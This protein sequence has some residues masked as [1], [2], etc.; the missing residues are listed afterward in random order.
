MAGPDVTR[1]SK[2]M[3]SERLLVQQYCE[4]AFCAPIPDNQWMVEF[5]N[6]F[7]IIIASS[8]LQALTFAG[9]PPSAQYEPYWAPATEEYRWMCEN[10]IIVRTDYASF[11]LLGVILI[12][13]IG[14]VIILVNLSLE[15]V[16]TFVQRA[17]S[18][19]MREWRLTSIFQLQKLAVD[20][21]NNGN[22]KPADDGIPVGDRR[23]QLR[24]LYKAVDLKNSQATSMEAKETLPSG[25]QHDAAATRLL[26][27]A[28]AL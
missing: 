3:G 15:N 11:S 24:A 18:D 10:Q 7:N 5:E 4:G 6:Y 25:K 20:G 23:E 9:D 28:S 22:W 8:Q 12:I 13:A 17:E 21:L 19:G 26:S 14:G 1:I 27:G 2:A 16:I